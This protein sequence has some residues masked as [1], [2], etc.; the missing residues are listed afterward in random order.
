VAEGA[1]SIGT[2]IVD[3]AGSKLNAGETL[4][5]GIDFDLQTAG[6]TGTINVKNGGEIVADEILIGGNGFLGGN[7]SVT[8]NITNHGG[9]LGA[10]F[11]PGTLNIFGDITQESGNFEVEIAGL[12]PG[13][14][15]VFMLMGP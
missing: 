3:G 8:G 6:G 5:V 15:D 7:G 1:G 12:V 11:S 9:T 14:F 10:G 13:Q 2:V 4:G